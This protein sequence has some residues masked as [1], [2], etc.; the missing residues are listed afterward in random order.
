MTKTI[1]SGTLNH[2]RNVNFSAEM[3]H[4]CL[5]TFVAMDVQNVGILQMKKIVINIWFLHGSCAIR[6]TFGVTVASALIHHSSVMANMI[7][8]MDLMSAVINV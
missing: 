3:V 7:V 2:V 4:V 6:Q 1:A 8:V 5:I